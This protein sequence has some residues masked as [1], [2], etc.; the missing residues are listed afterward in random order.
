[1]KACGS[2]SLSFL[3]RNGEAKCRTFSG[4]RFHPDLAAISRHDLLTSGKAD[5]AARMLIAM[6]AAK[7]LEDLLAVLGFNADAVVAHADE[8]SGSIL[9]A[10]DPNSRLCVATIFHSIA[11][12]ILQQLH[13]VCIVDWQ[14]GQCI[15]AHN[16]VCCFDIPAQVFESDP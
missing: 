14:H 13:Q 16:S 11:D 12:E 6:K 8:P 2:G 15:R 9:L 1:M 4:D 7:G 10:R 3:S 5:A